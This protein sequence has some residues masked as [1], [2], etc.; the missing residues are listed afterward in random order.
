[1]MTPEQQD[2][3]RALSP[4]QRWDVLARF[5]DE[6]QKLLNSTRDELAYAQQWLIEEMRAQDPPASVVRTDHWLINLADRQ[7]Y[8]YDDEVLSEL[9]GYLSPEEYDELGV[10]IMVR[11]WKKTALNKL[12]KAG[13]VIARTIDRGI[14]VASKRTD[15]ELT[16]LVEP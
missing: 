9:Q 6:R 8:T 3:L 13:G 11:K 16:E 5:I 12:H 7:T 10:P 4:R 15:V 14:T 2:A 1:M